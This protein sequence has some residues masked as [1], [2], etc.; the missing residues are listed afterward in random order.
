MMPKVLVRARW[1]SGADVAPLVAAVTVLA[2]VHMQRDVAAYR[3]R[4]ARSLAQGKAS[5]TE[6]VQVV[7]VLFFP[8]AL[9]A[10]LLVVFPDALT[11]HRHAARVA[12]ANVAGGEGEV[13]REGLAY[14]GVHDVGR[15]CE[16]LKE[17][18]GDVLLVGE[19]VP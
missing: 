6:G 11:K 4:A 5:G 15:G 2:R 18:G 10:D 19:Y 17:V 8:G 14:L 16:V 9:I 12:C 1:A 3:D 13:S 7:V